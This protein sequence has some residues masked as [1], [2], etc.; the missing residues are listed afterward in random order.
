MQFQIAFVNQGVENMLKH[1]IPEVTGVEEADD[2]ELTQINKRHV[3]IVRVS[4]N[5]NF[6]AG[7]QRN[8]KVGLRSTEYIRAFL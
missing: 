2:D 3:R 8:W 6:F 7:K 5:V 1:Y 4:V